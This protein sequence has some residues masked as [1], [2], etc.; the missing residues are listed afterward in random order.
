MLLTLIAVFF[1]GGEGRGAVG[2]MV[3]VEFNTMLSNIHKHGVLLHTSFFRA[4]LDTKR[5]KT[6]EQRKRETDSNLHP[7]EVRLT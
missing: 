2:F 4:N 6:A 7:A 5:A 3:G 1:G